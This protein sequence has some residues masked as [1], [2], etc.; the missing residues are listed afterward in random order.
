MKALHCQVGFAY[1]MRII[2]CLKYDASSGGV[3]GLGG[4]LFRLQWVAKEVY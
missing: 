4:G 3:G 2:A 1:M